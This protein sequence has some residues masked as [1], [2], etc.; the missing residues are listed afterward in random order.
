MASAEG[1]QEEPDTSQLA[2]LDKAHVPGRDQEMPQHAFEGVQEE[3]GEG[4]QMPKHL[5]I[6]TRKAF[7][8]N[9]AYLY[10]LTEID[11]EPIYVCT[12]GSQWA[13]AGEFL[14]LRCVAKE[15]GSPGTW[16]AFDSAISADGSTLQCRQ[17]VF[18]CLATDITQPGW[19]EW[20]I[21]YAA[22]PSDAGFSVDWQGDL[23]AETRMP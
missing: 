9:N 17:P 6:G 23:L 2:E 18:R 16:T 19:H 12:K 7:E 1:V 10:E 22:S 15:D 20:E 3:P 8:N 4:Q 13:R 21:N 14:V 5:T 11:S